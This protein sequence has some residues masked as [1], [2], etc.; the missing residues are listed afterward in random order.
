VKARG[1]AE[2]Q[3]GFTPLCRSCRGEGRRGCFLRF[4]GATM[5][6]TGMRFTGLPRR[7][8][9]ALGF[10]GTLLT[11]CAGEYCQSSKGGT[12]CGYLSRERQEP[13]WRPSVAAPPASAGGATDAAAWPF[14]APVIRTASSIDAGADS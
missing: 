2:G 14:P 13:G 11:G 5:F 6:G 9:M 7:G 8:L 10:A 1:L 3:G 4:N 12:E